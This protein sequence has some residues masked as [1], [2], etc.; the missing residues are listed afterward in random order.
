MVDPASNVTKTPKLE[1]G[2]M[3][4]RIIECYIS[5]NYA[6]KHILKAGTKYQ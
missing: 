4:D 1:V 2:L 5:F 6:F 3:Q